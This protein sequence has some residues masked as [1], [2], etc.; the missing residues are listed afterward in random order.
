MLYLHVVNELENFFVFYIFV[1]IHECAHIIAATFLKVKVKEVV[2]LSIGVNA[3]YEE[4]I[5]NLKE[6]IIS[7]TGPIA[8]LVLAIFLSNRLYSIINV[9]IFI[10]NIIPIYP[11]DG[12]RILRIILINVLG[13]KCGLKTYG[14][15][16]RTLI[17]I[18]SVITIIFTVY[19][20]NYYFLFFAIYVFL[21]VDK[22]IKKERIRLVLNEL[23]G[24]QL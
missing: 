12:G 8:S 4:N 14:V 16:L 15:V 18:L 20:R 10:T 21:L 11:L 19:F 7:M 3:R 24:T 5:S 23:I 9:V 22:E 1:I 17:C 13:Y 2:L 6:F